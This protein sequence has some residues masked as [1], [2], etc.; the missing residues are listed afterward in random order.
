MSDLHPTGVFNDVE[1][2]DHGFRKSAKKG[3]PSFWVKFKTEHGFVFNDFYLT[4]KAAERSIDKIVEMGFA[5]ETLGDPALADGSALAGNL[6]QVTVEHDTYEGKTSARVAFVNRNHSTGGA[7]RDEET[8][9]NAKQ[10]DAIFRKAKAAAPIAD[11]D[12]PF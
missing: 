6:V 5:G 2:V 11:D 1:I 4:D 3:T 7:T 12:V 8:A 10:F 9:A